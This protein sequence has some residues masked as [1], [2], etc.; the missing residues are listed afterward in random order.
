MRLQPH[1]I[2]KHSKKYMLLFCIAKFVSVYLCLY[3]LFATSGM[4]DPSQCCVSYHYPVAQ[5]DFRGLP[6][7]L[8]RRHIDNFVVEDARTSPVRFCLVWVVVVNGNVEMDKATNTNM[9]ISN[10]HLMS[11][12]G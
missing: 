12:A 9:I 1:F 8:G 7:C 2:Y 5:R 6:H 3:Q 4:G 11:I 10:I